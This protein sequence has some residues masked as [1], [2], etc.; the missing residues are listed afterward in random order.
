MTSRLDCDSNQVESSPDLKETADI[1]LGNIGFKFDESLGRRDRARFK[2]LARRAYVKLSDDFGEAVMTR[3]EFLLVPV[4]TGDIAEARGRVQLQTIDLICTEDNEFV[5]NPDVAPSGEIKMTISEF[6]EANIAHEFMH[7]FAQGAFFGSDAFTEGMVYGYIHSKYPDYYPQAKGLFFQEA[8][9]P[10]LVRLLDTGVD[11]NFIDK[12]RGGGALDS[13]LDKLRHSR[14]GIVWAEF[15][16]SHPEFLKLFSQGV[17]EERNAGK[18][19]FPK[20]E[21]IDIATAAESSFPAWL[22][23]PGRSNIDIA[24]ERRDIF[25][26][27][28]SR[29]TFRVVNT[30]FIPGSQKSGKIIP[31]TITTGYTSREPVVIKFKSGMQVHE[32][33]RFP[34]QSFT[35]VNMP[36]FEASGDKLWFQVGRTR[37]KLRVN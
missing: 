17:M 12:Q 16:R 6:K 32:G 15:I 14:W 20:R 24:S 29:D 9:H 23:G 30:G 3:P 22:S 13:D 4:S 8:Q 28:T 2:R 11:T 26:A 33:G 21:L 1:V 18:L 5:H 7:L 19:Y 35:Q 37:L 27:R 31:A 25:V 34:L 10:A 36:G